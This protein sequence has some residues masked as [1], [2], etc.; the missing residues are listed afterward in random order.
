MPQGV[1]DR[2]EAVEVDEDDRELPNCDAE[3]TSPTT[4]APGSPR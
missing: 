1:I 2:L 3:R 4:T